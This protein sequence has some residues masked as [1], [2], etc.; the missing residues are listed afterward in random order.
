MRSSVNCGRLR[1]DERQLEQ[2]VHLMK[3][4]TEGKPA[5]QLPDGSDLRVRV[6]AII[7]ERRRVGCEQ[8]WHARV[9]IDRPTVDNVEEQIGE[10][11]HGKRAEEC[12]CKYWNAE[13]ELQSEDEDPGTAERMYEAMLVGCLKY[14]RGGL[15]LRRERKKS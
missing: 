8:H 5:G 9:A 2:R 15:V 7:N 6:H 14:F 10:E 1:V 11:A 3:V 13:I 4:S 12:D